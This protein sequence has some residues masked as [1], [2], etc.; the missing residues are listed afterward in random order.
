VLSNAAS[1]TSDCFRK[2]NGNDQSDRY[3]AGGALIGANVLHG[4]VGE[5]TEPTRCL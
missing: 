1:V 2:P 4:S 5:R 3:L